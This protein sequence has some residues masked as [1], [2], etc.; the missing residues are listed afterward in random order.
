MLPVDNILHDDIKALPGKYADG[1]SYGYIMSVP[2]PFV[3]I[4]VDGTQ[5]TQPTDKPVIL[6][7]VDGSTTGIKKVAALLSE[8]E[9]R[10]NFDINQ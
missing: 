10:A 8:D 6:Y 9:L 5:V 1:K 7:E 2:N 4:E 3:T